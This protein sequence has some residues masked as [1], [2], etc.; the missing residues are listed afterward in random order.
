LP[1]KN[2]K[3]TD[4]MSG[5]CQSCGVPF[6]NGSPPRGTS[7]DGS[8]SADYCAFCYS[9]GKFSEDLTVEQMVER[10]IPYLLKVN[11]GMGPQ[12]ARDTLINFIPTLKRWA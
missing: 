4:D 3:E 8:E 6:E 9:G 5:L 12:Q 2:A 7:A 10:Q 1:I 11:L